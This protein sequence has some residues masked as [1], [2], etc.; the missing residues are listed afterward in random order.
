MQNEELKKF[1][2]WFHLDFGVLFESAELGAKD[3]LNNLSDHQKDKLCLE[4]GAL[5]NECQGKDKK[6]LKNAWIRLGA[7]WWSKN[8]MPQLL[9]S[10]ANRV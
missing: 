7:Q 3:Y 1:A 5:L 2:L 6:S 9:K 4:I 8:E 10:L